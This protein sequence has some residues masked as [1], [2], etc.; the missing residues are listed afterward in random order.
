MQNGLYG[1][2][3]YPTYPSY[4]QPMQPVMPANTFQ[5]RGINGRY[6]NAIEEVTAN[7]VPMDGTC[8]FFP[9]KDGSS[10]FVK[11]WDGNG[12][13]K[14]IKF[15]PEIGA[16][17]EKKDPFQDILARL[18][19]LDEGIASIKSELRKKVDHDESID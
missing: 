4:Q 19:A 2:G 14:T 18:N 3:F 9:V 1:Q 17:E 12:S 11:A 16:V 5:A 13:I 6:I 10:I 8:G 15:V 7:E